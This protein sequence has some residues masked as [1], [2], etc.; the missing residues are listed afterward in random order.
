M[1]GG[2]LPDPGV[3]PSLGSDPHQSAPYVPREMNSN[4]NNSIYLSYD[5]RSGRVSWGGKGVHFCYGNFSQMHL[6]LEKVIVEILLI[7]LL[8]SGS[9]LMVFLLTESLLIE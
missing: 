1:P 9:Q 7:E 2:S 5:D 6:C 4:N 3:T 8:S